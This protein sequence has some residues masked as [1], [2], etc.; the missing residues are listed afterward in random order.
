MNSN[1]CSGNGSYNIISS[2][3]TCNPDYITFNSTNGK[4]CNY[5]EKC[6]TGEQCNFNGKCD[7]TGSFCYCKKNYITFNS[8]YDTECNY[9]QK[10]L[11]IVIL[12]HFVIGITGATDIYL[13]NYQFGCFQLFILILSMT[14]LIEPV[15]NKIGMKIKLFEL[16]YFLWIYNF[17]FL[18][19]NWKLDGNGAPIAN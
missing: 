10:N 6:L 13:E 17:V 1:Q 4:E 18:F 12:L 19:M 8:L 16:V 14:F 2:Y 15:Y 7:E 3:C 11:V 5:K 9:K